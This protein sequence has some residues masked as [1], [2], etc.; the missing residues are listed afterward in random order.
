MKRFAAI[1]L[2][3]AMSLS[4]PAAA[5]DSHASGQE[6]DHAGSVRIGANLS[7]LNATRASHGLSDGSTDCDYYLTP[8]LPPQV[9]MMVI[10][11][12][13]ARFDL[14]ADSHAGPFGIVIGELEQ[15]ALRRMPRRTVVGPHFYGEKSD[16][17]LTWR[18]P[19]HGLALRVETIGGHVAGMYW[20]NWDAVQY[21]EG[22]L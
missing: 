6:I 10:H 5:A 16:H 11:G 19:G 8:S 9:T 15:E 14:S 7:T 12:R 21:V 1:G 20:G 13:V 22:C 4:L 3:M 18:V 2:A 17:Y